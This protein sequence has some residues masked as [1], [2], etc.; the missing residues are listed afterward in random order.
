MVELIYYVGVFY[1]LHLFF[2]MSFSLHKVPFIEWTYTEGNI[3]GMT[4]LSERLSLA[5]DNLRQTLPI[6]LVFAVLSVILEVD[7]LLYAQLWFGFRILYL[8]GAVFN[9]YKFKMVRPTVWAPSVIL[10][11]MMG[12]NLVS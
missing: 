9:L 7:N 12:T 8:L 10:L 3:S 4:A 11:F 2:R 5:S 1:L 6:F